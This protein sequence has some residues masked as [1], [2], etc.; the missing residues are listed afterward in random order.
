MRPE[1]RKKDEEEAETCDALQLGLFDG[2]VEW[3]PGV[4]GSR[5]GRS[6]FL[7]AAAESL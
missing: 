6:S 7:K 4:V 5:E 1:E 2:E 3:Q